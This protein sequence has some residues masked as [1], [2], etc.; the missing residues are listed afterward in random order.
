MR[1]DKSLG[2]EWG[3][4]ASETLKWSKGGSCACRLFEGSKSIRGFSLWCYLY[5]IHT[6][7]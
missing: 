7:T 1:K 6:Q 4:E 3:R 5:Y 2:G